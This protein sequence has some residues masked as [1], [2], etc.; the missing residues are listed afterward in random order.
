MTAARHEA[1]QAGDDADERSRSTKGPAE[2]V[3]AEDAAQRAT[4]NDGRQEERGR[5]RRR[6]WPREREARRGGRDAG[7]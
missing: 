7:G 6:R 5:R 1:S 4:M 3:E 2:S